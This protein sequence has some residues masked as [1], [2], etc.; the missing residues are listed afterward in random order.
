MPKY[1]SE[2]KAS[3]Y[4]NLMDNNLFSELP[5]K[6]GMINNFET[7]LMKDQLKT[8]DSFKTTLY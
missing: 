5:M 8:Y 3:D 7:V 2:K 4:L 1:G 6:Y